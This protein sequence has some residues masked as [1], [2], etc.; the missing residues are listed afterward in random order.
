MSFFK[1]ELLR[2]VRCCGSIRWLQ[3]VGLGSRIGRVRTRSLYRSQ[4]G[5]RQ[6]KHNFLHFL[7]IQWRTHYFRNGSN[8]TLISKTMLCALVFLKMFL[9][10]G[11]MNLLI[12]WIAQLGVWSI[13]GFSGN[14]QG[15]R[16]EFLKSTQLHCICFL[17]N[18]CFRLCKVI[19]ITVLLAI[20]SVSRLIRLRC[21]RFHAKVLFILGYYEYYFFSWRSRI[22]IWYSYKCL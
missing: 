5:K 9:P 8:N 6:H 22:L 2:C 15:S 4:D 14:H 3:D 19:S 20:C 7:W 11:Q 16:E 21:L 10:F 18:Y 1:G 17:R 12:F 13:F